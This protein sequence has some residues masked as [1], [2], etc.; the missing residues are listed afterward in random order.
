MFLERLDAPRLGT[1]YY[2]NNGNEND[3]P[4]CT[5]YCHD[6]AQESCE[7]KELKLFTDRVPNGFPSADKWLDN[8]SFPT[9]SKPRV[10]SIASF[11]TDGGKMHVCYIERVNEDGTCFISDSRYDPDKSLRND[12]YFRTVDNVVLKVGQ[13]PGGIG[14]VG[15]LIG[16]QYLPIN[17][18]RVPRDESKTQL[19]ITKTRVNCR[20]SYGLDAPIVNEG[21]YVPLGIYN[22]L[23]THNSDGYIWCKVEDG[24]WVAFD[25]E[26]AI[27]HETIGDDFDDALNLFVK[28]MRDEHNNSIAIKQGL[29]DIQTIIERIL[30][31]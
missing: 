27:L 17:D 11:S 31:L 5:K 18:I 14:G 24:H 13:I 12:R 3:M 28:R 10:G 6:R 7:N 22:V 29:S 26:W 20:S 19:E 25:N 15:Q 2:H 21:C 16:F 9:G 1:K 8:S 30:R 23:E 4:N